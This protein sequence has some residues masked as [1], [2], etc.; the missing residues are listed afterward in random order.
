MENT[1]PERI[2]ELV[3]RQRAFFATGTTREVKWRIGQLK[4]FKAAL[5]KSKL[6]IISLFIFNVLYNHTP[7]K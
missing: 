5:N 6:E 4:I 2:K 3:L 1:S 7:S